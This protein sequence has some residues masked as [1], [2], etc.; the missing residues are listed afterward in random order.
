MIS[1]EDKALRSFNNYTVV[2]FVLKNWLIISNI[3]LKFALNPSELC[4]VNDFLQ[5]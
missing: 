2:K 3:M 4:F 5:L 1:T